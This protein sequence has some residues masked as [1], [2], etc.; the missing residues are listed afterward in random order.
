MGAGRAE[1]R[2]RAAAT[3]TREV[4]DFWNYLSPLDGA[5]SRLGVFGVEG[6]APIDGLELWSLPDPGG[7][8]RAHAALDQPDEQLI[9][10]LREN[11]PQLD[12][13]EIR[14]LLSELLHGCAFRLPP[15]QFEALYRARVVGGA[16][17]IEHVRE[18]W[19]PPPAIVRAW[20]RANA[21]GESVFYASFSRSV[22]LCEVRP[23]VGDPVTI[24]RATPTSSAPAYF[25]PLGLA[26]QLSDELKPRADP[27]LPEI[28]A[29]GE[30][31]RRAALIHDF[32]VA[33]FMREHPA[34]Q[35]RAYAVTAILTRMILRAVPGL[36]GVA[37]PSV[38]TRRA[39]IAV[40]LPPLE[41]DRLLRPESCIE[42]HVEAED[43]VNFRTRVVRTAQRFDDDG[44]VRWS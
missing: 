21:P 16:V 30:D 6:E 35:P 43:D 10:Q 44:A 14:V 19:Y 3:L 15:V 33:E 25:F 24:L 32:L 7:K 8:V 9:A 12:D 31:R 18:A 34:G 27:R 1:I 39:S 42:V 20:G 2:S 5:R 13:D 37:Y 36:A 22:A 40:A 26:P 38:V 17:G 4:P 23:A 29:R 41:A 28:Y 11:G